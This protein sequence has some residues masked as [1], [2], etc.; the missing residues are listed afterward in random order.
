MKKNLI[1]IGKYLPGY[2]DGGPIR[3]IKNLVEFFK[4]EYEFY[5][6]CYDR[7]NGDTEPYDGICYNQWNKV[8]SA[9]VWYTS[10]FTKKLITKLTDGMDTIYLCGVYD[11][12]A[13]KTLSLKKSNKIKQDVYV[14]SMGVFSP[15]ALAQKKLKKY[16]YLKICKTFG[17][18]KNITW[19]VTS[20]LEYSELEKAIGKSK[21]IVAENLPRN[22]VPGRVLNKTNWNKFVF[23]SRISPKKNLLGAIQIISKLKSSIIFDIYGPKE[24]LNYWEQCEKALNQLPLNITWNYCG[25]VDSEA[26]QQTLSKY[27]FFLFPTFG[28]NYGHVIFEALSVGCIPIISDQTP[29]KII[30]EQKAGIVLPLENDLNNF[31]DELIRIMNLGEDEKKQMSLRAVNI[32]KQKID[33]SKKETGYR[34]IFK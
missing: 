1:I 26:A 23:Y 9:N 15:G 8:G 21:Y 34:K 32:A 7:D 10:R 19:S 14:A 11:S 33:N 3:T 27:D 22:S 29:W 2:K 20:E 24:E 28:E 6:L 5:I 25:V 13:F 16:V 4:G 31:A 17:L 30:T 12:Y 18:F